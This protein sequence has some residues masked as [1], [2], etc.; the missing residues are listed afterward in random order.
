[1]DSIHAGIRVPEDYGADGEHKL[2]TYWTFWFDRKAKKPKLRVDVPAAQGQEPGAADSCTTTADGG[3]NAEAG[4]SGSA[5]ATSV[6]SSPSAQKPL[7]AAPP[8]SAAEQV[9]PGEAGASS[10]RDRFDVAPAQDKYGKNAKYVQGLKEVNTV[11]TVEEFARTLAFLKGPNDIGKDYNLY[12]FRK[13]FVPAWEAMPEGGCWIV[14]F[15]KNWGNK[16]GMT[17]GIA[18][19]LWGRLMLSLI[20]E[21]CNLPDAVGVVLSTKGAQDILSLWCLNNQNK[22]AIGEFMTG[23]AAGPTIEFLKRILDLPDTTMLQYKAHAQ[24]LQD[25]ST[26]LN[27]QNFVYQSAAGS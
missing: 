9:S 5:G 10:S 26:Y 11:G 25:N 15:A 2:E 12:L 14:R 6:S 7:T 19:I 18:Q 1:M 20:G 24:S 3:G 16:S 27:A 13:G 22:L 23:P 4:E 8:G 21:E 17:S